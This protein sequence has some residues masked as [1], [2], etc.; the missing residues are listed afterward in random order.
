MIPVIIIHLSYGSGNVLR[1]PIKKKKVFI[2]FHH[3]YVVGHHRSAGIFS[4]L[5]VSGPTVDGVIIHPRSF[6]QTKQPF[7]KLLTQSVGNLRVGGGYIFF[8]NGLRTCYYTAPKMSFDQSSNHVINQ[9]Y[10][11][12]RKLQVGMFSSFIQCVQSLD[13]VL[14][15]TTSNLQKGPSTSRITP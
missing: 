12:I 14:N 11:P 13:S 2:F 4:L 15:S 8:E 6:D 7:S 10:W 3:Y 1:R 9:S 5:T